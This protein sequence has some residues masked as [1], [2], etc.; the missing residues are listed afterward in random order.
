MCELLAAHLWGHM[1]IYIYVCTCMY[2]YAYTYI[3][4]QMHIARKGN[5]LSRQSIRAETPEF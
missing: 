4:I 5:S 2:M 1:Y 3:L